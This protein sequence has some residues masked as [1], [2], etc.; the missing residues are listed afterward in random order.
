MTNTLTP[1]VLINNTPSVRY[2]REG[3]PQWVGLM[4]GI[5]STPSVSSWGNI[6]MMDPIFTG[7][8]VTWGFKGTV[9]QIGVSP[10]LEWSVS[11]DS[12]YVRTCVDRL[13]LTRN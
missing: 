7:R 3:T 4:W 5:T 1:R 10:H 13:C 9:L 8:K 6:A 2:R 11:S 12:R